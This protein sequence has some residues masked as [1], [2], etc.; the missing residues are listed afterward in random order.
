MK[1][2][3]V[4]RGVL[5]TDGRNTLEIPV[6]VP[7]VACL[8]V[9][10]VPLAGPRQ[11]VGTLGYDGV[12]VTIHAL[13]GSKSEVISGSAAAYNPG[14]F[15]VPLSRSGIRRMTFLDQSIELQIGDGGLWV[16]IITP[17]E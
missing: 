2:E 4:R 5:V 8:E 14:G 17:S 7:L 11:L 12:T 15:V 3:P 1:G 10:T 6:V 13:D 9:Q 16:R